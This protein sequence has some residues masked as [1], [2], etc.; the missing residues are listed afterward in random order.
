M[1]S[2]SHRSLHRVAL[3]ALATLAADQTTKLAAHAFAAGRTTG[4]V[5]PVRNPDFSLGIAHAPLPLMILAMTAGIVA[6]GTYLVH[7]TVRGQVP[8]WVTGLVLGGATA[9]LADRITSGSVRDFLATPWL[10][11]NV[12]D[13]AVFA[14]LLGWITTRRHPS[15]AALRDRKVG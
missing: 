15:N 5:V 3:I 14:G 6:V 8:A 4:T 11:A 12:A 7:A 2:H 13:L 1:R 10:I 9:N